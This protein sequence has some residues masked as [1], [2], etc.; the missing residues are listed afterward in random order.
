MARSTR[1]RWRT[2]S[3]ELTIRVKDLGDK[4]AGE[5]LK[6]IGL[7]HEDMAR[8]FARVGHCS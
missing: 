6:K 2:P 3:S 7:G 8:K 4:N 5:A 1:T